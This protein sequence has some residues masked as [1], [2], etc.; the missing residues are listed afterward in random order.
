MLHV[1]ARHLD[2]RSP[3]H[4]TP[5]G[6]SLTI[7]RYITSPKAPTFESHSGLCIVCGQQSRSTSL[8][9]RALASLKG[10]G[11]VFSS[12][13][14]ST[15]LV[16]DRTVSS[17]FFLFKNI[18]RG[19]VRPFMSLSDWTSAVSAF[20]SAFLQPCIFRRMPQQSMLDACSHTSDSTSNV[21]QKEIEIGR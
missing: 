3:N 14:S 16:F 7:S 9:L 5:F 1:E 13:A 10:S 15:A 17:V 4:L 18:V 6:I 20:T 8:K 2:C 19:F 12:S 11:L 21:R